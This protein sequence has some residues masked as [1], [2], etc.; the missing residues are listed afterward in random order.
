[1]R[2]KWKQALGHW[3]KWGKSIE[4]AKAKI[5]NKY[6]NLSSLIALA[7]IEVK[8]ERKENGHTNY[9]LILND[10]M[11]TIWGIDD[12]LEKVAT[13]FISREIGLNP[14]SELHYLFADYWMRSAL[15][16][17][18][19]E[20]DVDIEP[21]IEG[22]NPLRNVTLESKRKKNGKVLNSISWYSG[23][24]KPEEVA[25]LLQKHKWPFD[26]H[27]VIH[28]GKGGRPKKSRELTLYPEAIVCYLLK[29]RQR[30]T[31]KEIAGIFGWKTYMD[32]NGN[33]MSNTARNRIKLGT[34]ILEGEIKRN[35]Q[36]LT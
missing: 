2:Q 33:L 27:K 31:H 1:M 24:V 26:E 18:R 21:R 35:Y 5:E 20:S 10:N 17:F 3:D 14:E 8:E 16:E 25:R 15:P 4:K 7:K 30:M 36:P 32:S 6:N 19:G 23:H 28:D 11:Q 13:D 9:T 22:Y 29:R 12:E 34:K